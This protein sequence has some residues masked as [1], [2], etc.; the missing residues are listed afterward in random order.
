MSRSQR[1]GGE[2]YLISLNPDF[3]LGN[4]RIWKS[5]TNDGWRDLSV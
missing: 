2:G 5:V 1:A 4:Q 3:S